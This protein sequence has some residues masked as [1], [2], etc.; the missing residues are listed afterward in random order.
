MVTFANN[1]PCDRT[2][3]SGLE[4]YTSVICLQ[5]QTG[6]ILLELRLPVYFLVISG[7][8]LSKKVALCLF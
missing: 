6:V 3:D 7:Y 2:C 5:H 4:L 8:G 1:H